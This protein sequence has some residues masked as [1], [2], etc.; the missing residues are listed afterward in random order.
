MLT[1]WRVLIFRGEGYEG[2]K[3]DQQGFGTTLRIF[4]AVALIASL[5]QLLALRGTTSQQSF[6]EQL[7]TAAASLQAR[8]QG[9][10]VPEFIATPLN[11]AAQWMSEFSQVLEA[12]QPPLGKDLSQTLDKIGGWL[13]A[14]LNSL[15]IWLPGAVFLFI[16]AKLLRGTGS[17]RQHLS[18][19][20]LAFA[21]QVLTILG[22]FSL[23]PSLQTIS[24][25]LTAIAWLW[26]LAILIV[27]L[28]YAH[29]FSVARSIGTLA[30]GI[31]IMAVADTAV[32]L[33]WG[34]LTAGLIKLLS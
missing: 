23:V 18:L 5:G 17:V 19:V 34:A 10:F 8:A 3:N 30:L 29:G 31:L 2:V 25:A 26:S 6:Y 14:P 4:I 9:R 24:G 32:V 11:A 20:L 22:Q 1:F 12:G 33:F 27:A 7:A 15:V 16:C 28:M 21:P 13:S